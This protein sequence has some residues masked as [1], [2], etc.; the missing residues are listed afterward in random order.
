MSHQDCLAAFALHT[1][2]GQALVLCTKQTCCR[3][4]SASCLLHTRSHMQPV[5]RELSAQRKDKAHRRWGKH[6]GQTRDISRTPRSHSE[7][8]SPAFRPTTNMFPTCHRPPRKVCKWHTILLQS[9]LYF[10]ALVKSLWTGPA[11]VAPFTLQTHAQ[12]LGTSLHE[13][14][15]IQVHP[16]NPVSWTREGNLLLAVLSVHYESGFDV[17]Q[18]PPG[19]PSAQMCVHVSDHRREGGGTF[20]AMLM[21]NIFSVMRTSLIKTNRSPEREFL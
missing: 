18:N 5:Y 10:L 8:S 6:V 20:K 14:R 13:C 16:T 7:Q 17:L 19:N 4:K 15:L 21:K 12:V 1:E 9:F 2:L 11:H 3:A